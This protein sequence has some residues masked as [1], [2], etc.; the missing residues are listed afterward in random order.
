MKKKKNL[1]VQVKLD[2]LC[3]AIKDGMEE[4]HSLD[5]ALL[6]NDISKSYYNRVSRKK[7]VMEA[8]IDGESK[9]KAYWET[10]MKETAGKS[11]RL[12]NPAVVIKMYES[13]CREG[14]EDDAAT[15]PKITVLGIGSKKVKKKTVTTEETVIE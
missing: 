2:R 6:M 5:G 3:R 1:S 13:C 12:C 7:Q 9:R 10:K 14:M 8:V 4:G 15:V 11:L